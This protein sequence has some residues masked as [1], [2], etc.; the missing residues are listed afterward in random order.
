[1]GVATFEFART[2][3]ADSCFLCTVLLIHS[4]GQEPTVDRENFA[5]NERRRLGGKKNRGAGNFLGF[6]EP[7]HGSPQ[8]QL[9][10]TRRALNERRVQRSGKDAGRDCVDA[11]ARLR[12]FNG[13]PPRPNTST[14]RLAWI[15]GRGQPPYRDCRKLKTGL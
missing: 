11:Y 15:T 4:A 8:N 6:A 3:L 14:I 13:Q 1:M 12:K 2:F 9:L 10:A 7:T 5:G